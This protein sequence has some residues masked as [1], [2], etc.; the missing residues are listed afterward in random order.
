MRDLYLRFADVDEM[1]SVLMDF[2][3]QKEE[4][5][6][7]LYHPDICLDV[8]G[9]MFDPKSME[10]ENPEVIELPGYHANVRVINDELDISAL[11]DFTIHPETP[12]RVW[13]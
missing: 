3:F 6:A 5:Q 12:S 9:V 2:G 10:E 13:A 8:V 1:Q 11:D 7:G 4:E